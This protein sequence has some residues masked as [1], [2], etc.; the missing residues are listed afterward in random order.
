M[1][2]RRSRS[3]RVRAAE[4][5]E[6]TRASWSLHP[7]YLLQWLAP[8]FP[9]D[10]PLRDEVRRYLY[11]GREPFLCSHYLGLAALPFVAFAGIF[12]RPRRRAAL[13]LALLLALSAALALGRHG[14]AYPLLAADLVPAL[15]LLRLPAEGAIL[16]A[17]AF[18]LLAGLGYDAWSDACA[19]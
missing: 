15:D 18:A 5:S 11:Q 16:A 19:E 7:A 14:L 10:L 6:G 13:L 12:A 9:H 8:V 3:S 17:L 4:L 1:A 2:S